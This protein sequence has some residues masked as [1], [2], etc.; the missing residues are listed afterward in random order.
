MNGGIGVIS[1]GLNN[2]DHNALIWSGNNNILNLI[3]RQR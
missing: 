1:N 2:I 3:K